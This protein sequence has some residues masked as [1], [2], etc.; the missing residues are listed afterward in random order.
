M[1]KIFAFIT[2]LIG[3]LCFVACANKNVQVEAKE[4]PIGSEPHQYKIVATTFPQYDWAKNILGENP[5]KIELSLLLDSGIDLH[6]YQPTADD[7]MKIAGCDMFIYVGGESDKWV[8]N[9]L[10]HS[11][12]KNLKVINLIEVLGE[13]VK[14]EEIVEGMQDEH[15][16]HE[17]HDEDD[18]HQTKEGEE[19]HKDGQLEYDEHVWLSIKNAKILVQEICDK[20]CDMDKMN[21]IEYRTNTQK[22]ITKLDELDSK[23]IEL[24]KNAAVK[25]LL[26]G[27]RFPFRY[28]V[29][30]YGLSY[31]AAFSGCSAETEA[32]FET[33]IF[34]AKKVDELSLKNIMKIEGSNGRVADTIRTN[35]KEKNQEILTLNSMQGTTSKDA[36]AGSTYISIMEDNLD[37]LRKALE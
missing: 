12:N 6:N 32:S 30:D 19:S 2:I 16:E 20:I 1:K 5:S 35:T 34:L 27:D 29:D 7:I 28:M 25:T 3:S 14:H 8:E 15:E 11:I 36:Q 18:T 26:F 9:A 22:Y 10:S 24:I 33:I 13:K 4:E 31:Y 17:E 37:V 23:Y 21:E